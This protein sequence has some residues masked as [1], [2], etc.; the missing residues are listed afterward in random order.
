M[1][2]SRI[3]FAASMALTVV[4]AACAGRPSQGV[5]IPT[6]TV[7]GTSIVP[8][9]VATTRQ[10]SATDPGEM[11]SGERAA[12]MS[13]AAVT[14]SIPADTSRKIG[15]VQ[16]PT[17]LPG[18]PR[19]NFMTVSADY[20][21]KQTFA[22]S[23]AA[24]AKKSGR[25]KVL[26]FVHGFNNRFDDSVYRFAQIVHDSKVPV[27]PVLFTWP[28]RGE[29]RL[30]AYTYDRE[31]AN[32][33]RDALEELL[34]S[35]TAYPA[36]AEVS[37]LAHSMGN[38]VALE[39]LRGRSIR[40]ELAAARLKP[41]KLKNVLLVAPDVDVDVFRAQILRMG[42][43]RPRIALFVSQDD[44][45]LGLSKTIWGDVPRLGDIDPKLE[46]YRSE[47]AR[48]RIVT[49]DLTTLAKAGDDAHDRAFED[50]T[51]VMGMIKQ[52]L[53]EGQSLTDQRSG[54]ANSLGLITDQAG[55]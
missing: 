17:T 34:G 19:T 37:L 27:I 23:I 8:I 39:A 29:L 10:R 42:S 28:S 44:A 30:R 54:A 5:M 14:I 26:V 55:R 4:L 40:G 15:E 22:A 41:D 13:Y 18:D 11:F 36:V 49:F 7:A 25:S 31:S 3:I 47:L 50:V 35:L 51:S 43:A 6:A 21:E 16:W 46:P 9:F 32:Y 38:W 53:S 33:S 12:T 45:A 1:K 20:I 2:Q 24:F 48:D 52:R